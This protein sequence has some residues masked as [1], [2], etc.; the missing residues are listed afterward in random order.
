[1]LL[2]SIVSSSWSSFS[3][4]REKHT[5]FCPLFVSCGVKKTFSLGSLCLTAFFG[6]SVG[7][8][9]VNT[10]VV[11]LFFRGVTFVS[12]CPD[13]FFLYVCFIHAHN[14]IK[15]RNKSSLKLPLDLCILIFCLLFSFS[16]PW[17]GIVQIDTENAQKSR[18]CIRT[19]AKDTL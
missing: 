12:L 14:F 18:K 17:S 1:M 6:C 4:C 3:S 2:L 13:F 9:P 11:V 19:I 5:T 15:F 7:L 8:H 16:L 10:Y